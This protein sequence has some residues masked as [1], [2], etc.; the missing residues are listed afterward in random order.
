MTL[1]KIGDVSSHVKNF[2]E[3]L[4]KDTEGLLRSLK[5]YWQKR[6]FFHDFITVSDKNS[7]LRI[8]MPEFKFWC[9]SKHRFVFSEQDLVCEIAF[10]TIK[11][12]KE[13]EIFTCYLR[14][15][16]E[17]S[18]ETTQSE[19]TYNIYYARNVES[20]II[21]MIIQNA[22]LKKFISL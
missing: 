4:R 14:P 16:G 10:Y 1:K 19:Q 22:S 5:E 15:G 20:A 6:D 12:E 11:E 8:E 7:S 21:D 18:F 13:I 17:L 2:G 3:P 9:E